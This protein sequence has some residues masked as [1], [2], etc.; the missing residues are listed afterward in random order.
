M[1]GASDCTEHTPGMQCGRKV[2]QVAPAGTHLHGVRYSEGFC[3]R[4]TLSPVPTPKQRNPVHPQTL[5][6]TYI[7]H[8][9]SQNRSKAWFRKLDRWLPRNKAEVFVVRNGTLC[10]K[11]VSELQVVGSILEY[12]HNKFAS[13]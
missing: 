8:G 7:I 10:H 1:Y 2:I 5:L 9:R 3:P 12:S 4:P 6:A 13:S 11:S